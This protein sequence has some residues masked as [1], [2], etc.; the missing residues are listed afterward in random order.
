MAVLSISIHMYIC[1]SMS[2]SNCL[3]VASE[4]LGLFAAMLGRDEDA[5]RLP[6]S[7]P[8]V[9]LLSQHQVQAVY[10]ETGGR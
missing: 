2:S 4:N 10:E 3:V 5:N 9:G 7:M 6:Q 1:I 8:V